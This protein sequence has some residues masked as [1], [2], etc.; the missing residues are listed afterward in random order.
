MVAAFE[1]HLRDIVQRARAR[2]IARLEAKL[3]V[4]EGGVIEPTAQNLVIL[5]AANQWFAQELNRA[6]YQRLVT[7]F[8][9]E[10]QGALP[11]L[12][13]ILKYLGNQAGQEW[14]DLGFTPR[15]LNLLR[16]VQANTVMSMRDAIDST[17]A[18]AFT[19]GMFGV[20]GLKF[21]SLVETLTQKLDASIGRAR[22][23]ADT[24]MST[25]YATASA[26]S[27]AAIEKD[28]PQQE[29]KYRYSGPD[30]KL[31]R[32][33]CEHLLRTG[34]AYSREQ[35]DRMNNGQ[36]P[37]VFLTRG[38]WNCRRQW[39]LDVSELMSRRGEIQ[40]GTGKGGYPRIEPIERP[41]WSSPLV[42]GKHV[43][44]F[45]SSLPEKPT[46]EVLQGLRN[47]RVV[48]NFLERYPLDRLEFSGRVQGDQW[49]GDYHAPTRTLIVNAFRAANSY[50]QEFYPPELPSVSA[51]GRNLIEAMQRSLYHETAHHLLDALGPGIIHE[52]TALFRSERANPVSLRAKRN[53]LEYF[54][55]TFAAYR[56]EDTL[57]DKDPEGYDMVEAIL[58]ELRSR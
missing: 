53:V 51:A 58:R 52:V 2:T 34:K 5:R 57:A 25:F 30:D 17:A 12:Q 46:R 49:M 8:V 13:E 15:D 55:E 29:L 44:E 43:R 19:R 33:F 48:L 9:D 39:I 3:M 36:L 42:V 32:P 40:E 6:G 4:S 14:G 28:L 18:A 54:S 24:A 37:N 11:F 7:A 27:F 47:D 1:E 31:T 41:E 16:G 23:I 21:G 50:G 45:L 35:I 26:R 10:F 38:G 20:A 56:F 22:T